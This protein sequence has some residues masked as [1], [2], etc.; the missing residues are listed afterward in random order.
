[1]RTV[2]AL[3]PLAAGVLFPLT[4]LAQSDSKTATMDDLAPPAAVVPAQ[5]SM[6]DIPIEK[7][8]ET[9]GGCAILDKDFPGM[10]SHPMYSFFKTMTLRQIAAMSKGKITPDMLQQADTDLSALHGSVITANT[11]TAPVLPAAAVG[12]MPVASQ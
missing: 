8:A 11:V 6:L 4:L 5:E 1:M 7:I 2:S 10:R 9:T 12:T 3:L